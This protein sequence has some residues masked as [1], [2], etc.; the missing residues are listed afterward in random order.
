MGLR[1]TATTTT[2]V[3]KPQA[4]LLSVWDAPGLLHLPLAGRGGEGKKMGSSVALG[5]RGGEGVPVLA[6]V[7]G[8]W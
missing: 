2:S 8:A 3:N 7:R 5:P 4:L 1:L 6:F